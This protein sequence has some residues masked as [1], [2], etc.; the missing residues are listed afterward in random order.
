MLT[1]GKAGVGPISVGVATG[2]GTLNVCPI[3]K[4]LNKANGANI[5][6][7][8]SPGVGNQGSEAM[9]PSP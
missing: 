6:V 2:E 5:G 8:P 9:P 1:G 4:P 3:N 7:S